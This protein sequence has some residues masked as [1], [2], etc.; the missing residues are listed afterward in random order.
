MLFNNFKDFE[1][2]LRTKVAPAIVQAS[3]N[4]L[5]SIGQRVKREAAQSIG[6]YQDPIGTFPA[7]APLADSTLRKKELMGWGKDG[8]ADTP[9]YATGQYQ[10]SIN[11]NVDEGAMT[12]EIGTNEKQ[13][14]ALELGTDHIPPR[15]VFGPAGLRS[16]PDMLMIVAKHIVAGIKRT[17]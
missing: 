8:D 16:V 7:W 3:K 4:S 1:T 2:H 12:V 15:P 17:L 14:M 10:Q 11:Y 5:P 13:A 9:L 6:E